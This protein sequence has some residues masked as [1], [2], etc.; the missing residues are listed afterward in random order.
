M[1]VKDM[2]IV[3]RIIN[4]I[5]ICSVSSVL[6]GS[7]QKPKVFSLQNDLLL[8]GLAGMAFTPIVIA[9]VQP[10]L[11]KKLVMEQP[12][13]ALIILGGGFFAGAGCGCFRYMTKPQQLSGKPSM[14]NPNASK[15]TTTVTP[16]N[17]SPLSANTLLSMKNKKIDYTKE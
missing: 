16:T 15:L 17:S 1:K 9:F 14:Q 3:K 11:C 8:P 4:L 10:T 2:Y 7:E 12:E 6:Y 5:L 13:G